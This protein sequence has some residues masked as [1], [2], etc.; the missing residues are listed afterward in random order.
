MT[1]APQCFEDWRYRL[2][3]LQELETDPRHTG[4]VSKLHAKVLRYFISRYDHQP[5]PVS[6]DATAQPSDPQNAAMRAK[7][8]L[9]LNER[10]EACYRRGEECRSVLAEIRDAN[11]LRKRYED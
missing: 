1:G 4:W 3:D 11:T 9:R 7:L 5:L 8:V 10:N 6:A 2:R